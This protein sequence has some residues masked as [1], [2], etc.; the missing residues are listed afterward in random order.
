MKT[1]DKLREQVLIGKRKLNKCY[2]HFDTSTQLLVNCTSPGIFTCDLPKN[3]VW[4]F[5]KLW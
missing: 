3:V 5:V 2:E 4:R 1:L